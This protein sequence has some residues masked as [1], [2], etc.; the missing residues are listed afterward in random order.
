MR[1]PVMRARSARGAQMVA[2]E[3]CG[4]WPRGEALQLAAAAE[5]G[6]SHPIAAAIAGAA[7]ADA[8]GGSKLAHVDNTRMVAGQVHCC[9]AARRIHA[10]CG[11]PL[12][13]VNLPLPHNISLKSACTEFIMRCATHA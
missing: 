7:A 3:P 9:T 6:S 8:G 10:T 13:S 1:V 11:R 4:N 12:W 5:R 2:W